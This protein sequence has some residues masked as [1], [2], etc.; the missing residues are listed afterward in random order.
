MSVAEPE[1]PVTGP[2]T[3]LSRA[4]AEFFFFFILSRE[5]EPNKNELPQN[6][7]KCYPVVNLHD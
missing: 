2:L 6:G 4:G 1:P 7:E 5:S 3:V